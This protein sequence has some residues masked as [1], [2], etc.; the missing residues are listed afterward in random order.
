[1][2]RGSSAAAALVVMALSLPHVA[3]GAKAPQ[4]ATPPAGAKPA[5]AAGLANPAKTDAAKAE[6]RRVGENEELATL[7]LVRSSRG[8]AVIR[9][10]SGP[11][12]TVSPGDLLGRTAAVVKE[13]TQGRMVLEE[14]FVGRDDRPNK[15]R[16]VIT[17]GQTGGT[18]YLARPDAPPAQQD[19][20]MVAPPKVADKK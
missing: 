7:T 12:Q 4:A 14:Y 5:E 8:L 11:Q 17:D 18:R 3:T 13:I 9:F 1:M 20:R 19:R 16:V 2:R 10:E 6:A 15:A